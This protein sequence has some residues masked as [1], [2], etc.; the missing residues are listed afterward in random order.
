[1]IIAIPTR[2][3]RFSGH[4][5]GADAFALY[6]IDEANRELSRHE[7]AAP[8]EHGRG[9]FPMW[10]RNQRV[11]TVLAGGMGVVGSCICPKCGQR[12]PHNRGVPC[13]DERCKECCVALIR[14]G[15]AHHQ[16]IIKRNRPRHETR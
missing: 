3:G 16:E 15:S 13:L 14:K 10:L 2:E 8:P 12:F 9:V 7:M 5:G 1:M 4:F 11:T 6:T